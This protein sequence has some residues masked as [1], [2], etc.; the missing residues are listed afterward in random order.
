VVDAERLLKDRWKQ[1]GRG[2]F[3]GPSGDK[4]LVNDLLDGLVRDYEQ[5]GRRSVDT[6]KG[7]LVPVR[8]A[9]GVRSNVDISG[10]LI[11]RYKGD[12]LAARTRRK[13]LVAVATLNRELAALKRHSV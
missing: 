10:A 4:V 9:F 11:E 13:S 12:R 3:V 2:K 7:R 5:N 1:I 8:A 6:L